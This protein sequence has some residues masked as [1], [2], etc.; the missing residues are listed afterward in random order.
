MPA[1]VQPG[2]VGTRQ[3]ISDTVFMHQ[4][5][6]TPYLSMIPKGRAPRQEI[7][8]YQMAKRT[9]TNKRGVRDGTD[10]TSFRAQETRKLLEINSHWLQEGFS[11]GKKAQ[12]F[13][14]VAGR[15]N[16]LQNE[17]LNAVLKMKTAMDEILCDDEDQRDEGTNGQGSETRGLGSWINASAQTVRPVDPMF[18]TPSGSIYTGAFASL[19]EKDFRELMGSVW[20]VTRQRKRIMGLLGLELKEVVNSWSIYV[21]T[22]G[23]DSV[24]RRFDQQVSDKKLAAMIDVLEFEGATVELHLSPNL[25]KARDSVDDGHTTDSLRR[26]Y[27]IDMDGVELMPAQMPQRQPL[28]NLG[29]GPRGFVD[30]I[31]AHK[32]MPN[33]HAK[34]APG[35]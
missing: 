2:I 21:P 9:P 34:I 15:K 24:V 3:D 30:T 22:Q 10:V 12:S 1:I 23:S 13:T 5:E 25:A 4:A 16:Q 11:V 35:S 27:F 8:Q 28:P 7:H 26:G 20:K 6:A 29:G 31:F 17:I 18:R 32:C 14:D 33:V 19:T